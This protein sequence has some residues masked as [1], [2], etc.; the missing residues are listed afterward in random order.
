MIELSYKVKSV[1]EDEFTVTA[2]VAGVDR[3]VKISGVTVEMVSEDEAMG[4]TFR[5]VPEDDMEATLKA[6]RVGRTVNVTLSPV[7]KKKGQTDAEI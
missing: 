2:P 7:I 3:Q 6:F 4:H 1:T 5:F